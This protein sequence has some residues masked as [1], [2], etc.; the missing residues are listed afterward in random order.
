[1]KNYI[2]CIKK[3]TKDPSNQEKSDIIVM[4]MESENKLEINIKFYSNEDYSSALR[5]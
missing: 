5:C 3:T 1:M 2:I 4:Q